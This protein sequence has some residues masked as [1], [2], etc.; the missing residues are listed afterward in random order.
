M[1]SWRRTLYIIIFAQF[2]SAV[3]FSTIFP[4]LPLYVE[5]L[6][7]NTG[8]SVE[9]LTGLVFSVQA[10]TMM[11]AGPIWGAL[12][13]RHGRKLMFVRATLGG[14]VVILLMAFVRSAE[15]LIALR[16]VQGMIT[17]VTSAS[18]ALVAANVP[19]DRTGFALGT[20]QVGLWGGIAMGPL[21]GG[22][23]SDEFG[24][25]VAFFVTAVLLAFSGI[26]VWWGVDEVFKPLP[27]AQVEGNG[28]IAAW[29]HV[30]SNP[31][32]SITYTLRFISGLARS[33]YTPFIPLFVQ[34][35]MPESVRVATITGLVTGAASIATT[36]SAIYLGRLSD[37]IGAR[38]V[39][40][41]SAFAAGVFFL[42]QG[43]VGTVWLLLL[44]QALAGAAV[45][46]VMPTL[47][48]L[49]ARYTKPG[50]EGTV[51]GLENSIS[52][53]ARA[54]APMV[55]ATLAVWVG[56][57]GVFAFS[58][59]F[60]LVMTALAYVRLPHTHAAGVPHRAAAD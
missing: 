22:V 28:F 42:P 21:I 11:L 3:G 7:S 50:E 4:F 19:R 27:Q 41:V 9:V 5:D 33:L 60:F 31:G 8:L 55:G 37:R 34:G 54:V 53:G 47:S 17:G 6:G 58:G 23:I 35:L 40:I 43:L 25:S 15:E 2:I 30:L 39:L 52:A 32:V 16:A 13:D 12:A 1:V 48:S 57:R 26:L 45:G 36:A 24:Y 20:L 14:S 51:Y 46:G 10:L 38:P 56:L 49:L 44:L 59:M 29:R 18:S